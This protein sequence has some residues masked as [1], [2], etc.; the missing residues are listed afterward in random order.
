MNVYGI[1]GWKNAGKTG[2]MERLVAEFTVRGLKVSTIKHAHHRFDIDHPGKDSHRHREAGAN[3]VV[4]SSGVRW[5]HMGELR[6]AD[7]PSLEAHL[8]RLSPCDLV[9]IEGYKGEAHPKI[10]AHRAVTGSALIAPTDPRVRAVASDVSLDDLS[11]P[12]FDLDD[13]T[14]IADFITADVMPAAK[15]GLGDDCF[16]LPADV[17]WVEAKTALAALRE[18]LAV[19]VE[20]EEIATETALG[21]VLAHDVMARRSNPPSANSAVDGYGFFHEGDAPHALNL[22]EGR[23]AAGSPFSGVVSSGQAVRILT[24]AM[25][26]SGVDTVVLQEDV[27]IEGGV[28]SF[29]APKRGANCRRA[30]ED[31]DAGDVVLGAGRCLKPQDVAFLTAVG[32]GS[33]SVRRRLRVGVLSTGD[34]LA[35]PEPA[36]GPERTY[37][38]NRPML[39]SLA[40]AWGHEPVDLGHV[41]DDRD[42]LCTALDHGAQRADVI[43]TSGGASAGEEDHVSTLL[44]E[45]G[46]M[47]HWRIAIKPGRP[48][49][50]AQ[51]AGVPV[52]GL[53]GNPVAAF[54]CALMFARPSFAV[55]GGAEWGEPQGFDVPA[56]FEK[57]KKGGRREYLRARLR[58]GAVEVFKSEGSGRISGLSWAEGLVELPED[59]ATISKG[60]LVR[61]VPFSS[62]G[63]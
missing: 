2:L 25:I 57:R 42:A 36:Q 24:G 47:H 23:S 54:V 48:L 17:D 61:Y 32:V 10:E 33:V 14:A 8:A 9:L 53:P 52:F 3:E 18:R 39:L 41:P 49:A 59:A 58:N 38:A 43:V 13:T 6:G 62:F 31:V 35:A 11:V 63:I 46:A 30:G 15:D 19:V 7:E 5:A 50:L 45:A 4:L 21:R 12:V 56:A 40:M 1:T 29:S 27:T 34:E 60:D 55:L 37:D 22:C 26:P 16:A 51:W 28:V 44:T 20:S